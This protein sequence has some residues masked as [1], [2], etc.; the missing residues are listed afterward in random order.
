MSANINDTANGLKK[1]H[2]TERVEGLSKAINV[3]GA[4]G[5]PLDGHSGV[6]LTCRKVLLLKS[7]IEAIDE[8]AT[9]S[10]SD[11]PVIGEIIGMTWRALKE[12]EEMQVR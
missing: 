12:L 10:G 1:R 2:E 3:C 8:K 6:V 11:D 9:D 4:C 5:I 7:A